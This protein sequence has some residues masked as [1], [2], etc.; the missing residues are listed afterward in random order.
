MKNESLKAC[1]LPL[2]SSTMTRLHLIRR[3]SSLSQTMVFRHI[4][5]PLEALEL[6]SLLANRAVFR[7]R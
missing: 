3:K 1:Q 7:P 6:R 5:L 2:F 4:T